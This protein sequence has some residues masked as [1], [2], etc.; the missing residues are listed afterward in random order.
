MTPAKK[1]SQPQP[2]IVWKNNQ[3]FDHHLF[4][5]SVETCLKNG[6]WKKNVVMLEK[7]E[8]T[9]FYHSVNS[10]GMAQQY[11]PPVAGHF[12]EVKWKV[13]ENGDLVAECG[14]AL[15]K[16]QKKMPNGETKTKIERISFYDGMNEK[17]I[18]DDHTHKFE[19]KGSERLSKAH[20]AG[21]Q[22]SNS[23]AIQ[24]MGS[25]FSSPQTEETAE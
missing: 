21:I 15:R 12:H 17:T 13:A 5:A 19:Y 4:K 16:V 9:H 2:N 22:A 14:P 18:N 25:G 7:I 11:T 3:H 23:Q 6:S 1:T 8:H 10:Q 24:S 20:V